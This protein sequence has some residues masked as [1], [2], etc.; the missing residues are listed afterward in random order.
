MPQRLL[1]V[2]LLALVAC[3]P[4]TA[5]INVGPMPE[6]GTFHGVW[7]ST[8]Y[9]RM[10]LCQS[11][12]VVVG[13]YTKDERHGHL[14]GRVTGNT[15]RFEWTDS[16]EMVVGVPNV[17]SGRGYFQFQTSYQVNVGT[18]EEATVNL[19]NLAGEWGL[20]DDEVGGGIWTALFMPRERPTDCYASARRPPG[21]TAPDGSGGDDDIRF[22]DEEPEDTS[23]EAPEDT[24]GSN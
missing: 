11:Q 14:Q 6:G 20:E 4:A 13:E 2:T 22:S 9:G 23:V 21:S 18:P 1:L 7:Q 24:S 17:T 15:L 10:H 12:D 5:N 3:G 8:Q 19:P 16:R